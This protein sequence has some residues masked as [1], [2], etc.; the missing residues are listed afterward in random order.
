MP[1][2]KSS[3]L[4]YVFAVFIPALLLIDKPPQ[5][6]FPINNEEL[7]LTTQTPV[8]REEFVSGG[9]T[10]E[11]HSATATELANGDIGLF[12][13][14]GSREGAADVAIYSRFLRS[15]DDT[16]TPVWS[17]VREVIGRPAGIDGLQRHM[18]KIG[19]PLALYH[20]DKLWL[21]FV[22]VSIGGWG[23]SSINL[24]QSGDNGKSWG[25]PKRLVT[26]PLINI[27][28]LVKE[29]AVIAED[30]SI[31]LPVYHE[32]IGKFAELLHLDP[33]G[34]VI[35]KY[36]ITHGRKATQPV[37][38]PMSSKRAVAF[39]RNV[40]ETESSTIL[41]SLTLDGGQAGSRCPRWNCPTQTRP[42]PAFPW[43]DPR[44]CCWYS[45]MMMKKE[46]ILRWLTRKTIET[47]NQANG[48][49]SIGSN[50]RPARQPTERSYTTPTPTR[51]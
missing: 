22:T 30:G 25:S 41:S 50:T 38:L 37:V 42:S 3:W 23:G 17:E 35:D 31:L 15:R 29:R 39:L 16:G 10:K 20:K 8:I 6:R 44:N 21:F 34:E 5:I 51:F 7:P 19:N 14:A 49:F 28:T 12:W 4:M 9:L 36:R 26:S 1:S 32:F 33:Q 40:T 46:P 27:S 13:Y 11:V 24:I 43:T 47:V 45:I 48:K 18:R 2:R